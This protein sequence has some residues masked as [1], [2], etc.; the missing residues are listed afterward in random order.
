MASLDAH[1][2]IEGVALPVSVEGFSLGEEA[3]GK[4]SRNGAGWLV[5]ERRRSK[6]TMDFELAPATFAEAML[7]RSLILGEGEYWSMNSDA[8]GTKGYPV[9]GTGLWSGATDAGLPTN[10]LNTTGAWFLDPGKTMTVPGSLFSQ[11]AVSSSEEAQ[12]GASLVA[13]RYDYDNNIFSAV[14]FAWRWRDT[15]ATVK[16]EAIWSGTALATPGAFPGGETFSVSGGNLTLSPAAG[17]HLGYS[18]LRLIPWY[19]PASV[20]D[21]LVAGRAYLWRTLPMLPRVQVASK[22]WPLSNVLA[23]PGAT[24]GSYLVMVGEVGSSDVVSR[25]VNGSWDNTS[26]ALRASLTEV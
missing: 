9:T 17:A 16:R 13:W 3:V 1:V 12:Q 6:R 7:Y 5:R 20:L 25:A 21:V 22:F 14:G 2:A 11:A 8:W 10:L 23:S 24:D 15:T 19:L 26:L 18:H 4:S